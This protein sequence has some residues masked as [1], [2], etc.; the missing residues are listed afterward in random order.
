MIDWLMTHPDIWMFIVTIALMLLG[1]PVAFTL[2]GVALSFAFLAGE[3]GLFRV[4][5]LNF[6][7]QRVWAVLNNSVIVAAPLFIFMGLLLERSKVA[8]QMLTAMARL[9]GEKPGGLLIATT[10]VGA[11]MAASTG[12]VGATVVTMG[13]LALPV[14]LRNG[15]DPAS[16]SGAICAAGTLGQIIPPS[17][18]LVFLGDFL[19]FANQ[20]ANLTM[21]NPS[22]R[23][24]GVADL[25]A[26]CLIPGLILVGLY[27]V[28]QLTLTWRNPHMAPALPPEAIRLDAQGV[29]MEA[30]TTAQ[31]IIRALA[32]PLLL[33]VAVLGSILAGVA[34]PTEASG[35]GAVGALF[36]AAWR[37]SAR[38]RPLI[39]ASVASAA[40]IVIL[41]MIFDMRLGREITSAGEQ[42]A[43]WASFAFSGIICLGVIA[44][45]WVTFRS[46]SLMDVT[47]R[48]ARITAMI[49][50]VLIG[51]TLFTLVFRGLGGED[52]IHEF[53]SGI[54]AGLTGAMIFTMVLMFILGFFLDFLEII[55]ILVPVLC[56]VLI[57]MGADPVWLGVMIALNL[58]T[59]FL[60]PPFGFALF[61]LRGV[62][63]PSVAT[64]EIWR[65]ATPYIGLQIF[66][67]LILALYPPTATWLPSLILQ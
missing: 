3:L 17:I 60:T 59:S 22:G 21:G 63:P 50:T 64:M 44:S 57:V 61:Y 54:P 33:I 19:T 28:W 14:M 26:G 39:M 35:V 24:V 15:Y 41:L 31:L 47:F 9:F 42:L 49:F 37:E 36:L 34:T 12:I 5:T 46:G 18:V 30:E 10:L 6:L 13:V 27:L 7:P 38:A 55:F 20:Q 1:F 58:Q 11:L 53:M 52:T 8:E 2:A 4:A 65:G 40:I 56:P 29:E 25:F 23:S 66:T 45:L 48:T 32:A 67:L 51:A 43:I 16:A 62:A